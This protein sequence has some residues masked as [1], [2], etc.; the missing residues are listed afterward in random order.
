MSDNNFRNRR[1]HTVS[2]I[3]EALQS[4]ADTPE[5]AAKLVRRRRRFRFSSTHKRI[6]FIIVLLIVIIPVCA[7]EYVR[8]SYEGEVTR[9]QG[10][11]EELLR[12]N[13][14]Q[15]K[16]AAVTSRLLVD[17]NTQLTAI[18]SDLC[19]GGLLDNIAKLYPRSKQAYDSCANYKSKL[20]SLS[21]AVATSADQM[22]YLET[23][24][25]LLAGVSKPLDDQ[26]AILTAQQ[27]NW[28]VFVRGLDQMSVPVSFSSA[29]Q[30]LRTASRTILDQW[31]A[32][33]QASNS[34]DSAKF[35][36]ART[37]IRAAYIEFQKQ[38]DVFAA[39]V[40][41]NQSAIEKAVT[42]L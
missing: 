34:Y 16:S 41:Q 8:W 7:G 35:T 37:K 31:I 24:Q 29:H 14:E 36:E 23:L 11:V 30:A 22:S 5:P 39:S 9:A 38:A 27:E 2:H 21:G 33:V 32:L 20:S 26:F 40:A 4:V 13:I 6:T 10:M 17:V 42:G 25:P 12:Q 3:E 15:Q 28:Q 18:T 1:G 19:S